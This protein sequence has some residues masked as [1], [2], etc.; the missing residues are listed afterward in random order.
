MT[1]TGS[2]GAGPISGEEGILYGEIDVAQ[3]IVPKQAHDVIG[4]YQRFDVFELTLNRT[5]QEAVRIVGAPTPDD[6]SD[7]RGAVADL[8]DTD[9]RTEPPAPMSPAAQLSERRVL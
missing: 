8:R 6:L 9:G 7:R 1:P 4:Y 2:V 3:S 5:K